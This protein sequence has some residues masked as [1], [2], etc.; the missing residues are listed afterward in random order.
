MSIG[1]G[2][3]SSSASPTTTPGTSRASCA[4]SAGRPTC[5][6]G[7]STPGTDPSTTART[8]ASLRRRG[9]LR[10]LRF[11]LWALATTTSSTSPARRHALQPPAARL[12]RAPLLGRRGDPAAEAARQE[13]RLLGQQL[14]RRRRADLLRGLGRAAGLRRLPLARRPDVCSDEHNLAW[15]S[16]ATASPTSRS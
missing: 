5:S 15:G 4:S 6:T 12:F 8:T 11:Y 3:S 2:G 16:S 7:T 10:H 9:V 1:A 14:P 13:D